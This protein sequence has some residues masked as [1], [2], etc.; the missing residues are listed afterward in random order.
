MD[1]VFTH[2]LLRRSGNQTLAPVF[3]Q[4]DVAVGRSVAPEENDEPLAVQTKSAAVPATPFTA[5]GAVFPPGGV[6]PCRPV[7]YGTLA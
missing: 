1:M 7:Q 2:W 6:I 4:V 5:V 3:A